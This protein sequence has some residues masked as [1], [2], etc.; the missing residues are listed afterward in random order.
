MG[1]DEGSPTTT[2]T[3]TETTTE[4]QTETVEPR[5]PSVF[6]ITVRGGVPAGGIVRRSVNKGDRVVVLVSSDVPDEVH[7]HGYDLLRDVAPGRRARIAFRATIP[8][9]FEIELEDRGTQVAELT[10]EP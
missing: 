4:M 8:G 6:R 9:R 3:A 2:T 7:V 10:V 5:Q 1:R